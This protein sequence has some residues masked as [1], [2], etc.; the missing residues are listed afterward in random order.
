MQAVLLL[1]GLALAVALRVALGGPA[2]ARSLP[3]GLVFAGCLLALCAAAGA[4]VPLSRRALV[5]GLLGAVVLCLPVAVQ[6]ALEAAPLRGPQG[7]ATWALV[8]TV[9][10]TAEEVFLRGALHDA[11][12]ALAGAPAAVGVGALAFALLHVPLYGWSAVPLDLAVGV[13]LGGLR[14]AAGTPLAPAV[15]HVGADLAGWFLR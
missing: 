14:V 8:V 11:V 15:A 10:A 12:T 4:R 3:A 9:V 7:F 2:V 13:V 5:I 6:R 1:G